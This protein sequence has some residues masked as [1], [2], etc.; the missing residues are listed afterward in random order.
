VF[1]T[2]LIFILYAII[3]KKGILFELDE[4]KIKCKNQIIHFQEIKSF[5][6][7]HTIFPPTGMM[8]EYLIIKTKKKT[9]Y[10]NTYNLIMS[11]EIYK[12]FEERLARV[13]VEI[14][15]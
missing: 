2:G 9:H 6:Y 12:M 8:F 11:E 5:R 4:E 14:K 13:G 7:S 10:I 1:G 3:G 15:L